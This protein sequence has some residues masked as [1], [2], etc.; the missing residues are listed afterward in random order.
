MILGLVNIPI[1]SGIIDYVKL[2]YEN[3]IKETEEWADQQILQYENHSGKIIA[4]LVLC[5]KSLYKALITQRGGNQV[6]TLMDDIITEDIDSIELP[7]DRIKELKK[8]GY[9][10]VKVFDS[11]K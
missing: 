10:V 2:D 11:K 5:E 1:V 9:I 3:F 4:C 6:I 8:E 7:E